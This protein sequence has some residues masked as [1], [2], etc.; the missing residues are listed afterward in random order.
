MDSSIKAVRIDLASYSS[1]P[2]RAFHTSW[3]AFFVCFFAWFAIAPLM[4]VVR[5]RFALTKAQMGNAMIASVAVTIFARLVVG[6][7]LDRFGPRR[8]YATLLFVGALPVLG[9][10][11]ADTY[12][13][14]LVARLLVGV[15]GASFVVTQYHTSVMF[16]PNVVG[17]A[18]AVTAGW[19]NLG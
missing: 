12:S 13:E 6:R 16:A 8:T 9:I 17:T 3:M 1:R 11:L 19:G 4:P 10:G 5:D 18:N 7:V 14:F 15:I 2:M